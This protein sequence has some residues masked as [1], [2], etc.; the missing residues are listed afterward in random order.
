MEVPAENFAVEILDLDRMVVDGYHGIYARRLQE[1]RIEKRRKRLT[2]ELFQVRYWTFL[3]QVTDPVGAAVL[4][5]VE[6]IRLHQND[7]FR[8]V[9]LGGPGENA[10][11]HGEVVPAPFVRRRGTDEDNLPLQALADIFVV[12]NIDHVAGAKFGIRVGFQRNRIGN[13]FAE[14]DVLRNVNRKRIVR[15]GTCDNE[16]ILHPRILFWVFGKIKKLYRFG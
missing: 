10:S 5:A 8:P 2:V 15:K 14:P 6:Q 13:I 16:S 9:F 7:A 12:E 4:C 3:F 1:L 11:P